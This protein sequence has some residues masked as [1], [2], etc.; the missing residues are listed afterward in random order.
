[1]A[2]EPEASALTARR[3]AQHVR[4][5]SADDAGT[6][7]L[8]EFLLSRQSLV[9]VADCGECAATDFAGAASPSRAWVRLARSAGIAGCGGTRRSPR[10]AAGGCGWKPIT[11][12]FGNAWE[13]RAAFPRGA[14]VS[15][16]VQFGIRCSE[17]FRKNR[18][19]NAPR[20]KAFS[21][22][23]NA[24]SPRAPPDAA[25]PPRSAKPCYSALPTTSTA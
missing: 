2:E 11:S 14:G 15:P 17:P 10:C 18:T 12:T 3:A 7:G 24:S 23:L 9:E 1:M 21:R 5:F 16:T 22:P 25:W 8:I 4:L 20:S 19:A 13:R 6:H